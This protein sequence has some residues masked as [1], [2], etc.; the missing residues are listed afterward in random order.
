MIKMGCKKKKNCCCV[1]CVQGPQ[2]MIGPQGATGPTG[3]TGYT[4]YTG[5]T[6]PTGNTGYT[7]PTGNTGYT[8]PTG[9]TGN[10]GYTGPTGNTGY[11]GMTGFTGAGGAV[12]LSAIGPAQFV[13]YGSQPATVG[14]GQPF[15]YTTQIIGNANITFTTM[16]FN[17]P[18]TTSGTVFT[19]GNIGYYEVNY[20]MTY[21]TPGGVVLY[22][23]ST[24]ATMLPLAYTMIGNTSTGY[25]GGSVIIQTTTAFSF[26]SV[27]AGAGNQAAIGIPPDSSTTNQ[28]AT[29]VSFKQV[30]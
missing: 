16:V 25:V 28:S 15:T 1:K 14:A 17:P 5:P 18:F 10:T 2:G 7:G 29:T 13:Q 3:N 23:G 22:L 27:N 4:G 9:P 26:V 8:G 20:Q 11:T 6:G 12:D 30:G 21:P 24:I 19:L